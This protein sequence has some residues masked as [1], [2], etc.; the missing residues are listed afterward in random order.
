MKYHKSI[1]IDFCVKVWD[2]RDWVLDNDMIIKCI[3]PVYKRKLAGEVKFE[4][5]K[6]EVPVPGGCCS[7]L[8]VSS[9]DFAQVI[10]S[11]FIGDE[12]LL[13]LCNAGVPAK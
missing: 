13:E 6:A 9:N 7:E 10:I 5:S 1:L 11:Y 4:S 2:G 3:D 12:F 8:R